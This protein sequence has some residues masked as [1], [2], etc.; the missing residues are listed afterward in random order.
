VHPAVRGAAEFVHTNEQAQ[1]IRAS[2]LTVAWAETYFEIA[3][4][5][6][7]FGYLTRSDIEIQVDSK[8]S[9]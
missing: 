1:T 8:E 9:F 6:D 7:E 3:K 4:R 5:H 2:V